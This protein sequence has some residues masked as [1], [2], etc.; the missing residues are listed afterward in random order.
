MVRCIVKMVDIFEVLQN[1][2][3]QPFQPC[4]TFK[5]YSLK[6]WALALAV[7][8]AVRS[9]VDFN[10]LF[11]INK[12]NIPLFE[13]LKRLDRLGASFLDY[14]FSFN[15]DRWPYYTLGK[16]IDNWGQKYI[17]ASCWCVPIIFEDSLKPYCSCRVGSKE[18][19]ISVNGHNH[20]CQWQ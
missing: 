16:L 3:R 1:K 8:S 18:K 13:E 15:E 10:N 20:L 2:K 5:P 4:P 11:K 19:N 9:T 6:H 14:E 12:C 7:E 17:A